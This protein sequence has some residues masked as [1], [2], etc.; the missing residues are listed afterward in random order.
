MPCHT[1]KNGMFLHLEIAKK[2]A[3]NIRFVSGFWIKET[4]KFP[5]IINSR[6]RQVSNM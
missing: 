6:K 2:K 4:I 5:F 1:G 3:R